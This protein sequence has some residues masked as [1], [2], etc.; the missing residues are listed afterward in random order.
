MSA[1]FSQ[2]LTTDDQKSKSVITFN[3]VSRRFG[4]KHALKNISI[5]IP[6]GGVFGL[7]GVNGA[8]KT[9]LIKHVLGLLRAKQGSVNVF[10]LNPAQ[11]PEKVL[12][13]IGYMSEVAELPEWM[14]TWE[15][16]R[17]TKAFYPNW[18][19]DYCKH[20]INLFEID[21]SMK[22]RALS[23]GQKARVAL[24]LALSHRPELLILD[25]PSSGLDPLVRRDILRTVIQ[26]VA[27]DG[28]TVLFSSHLLEEVERIADHI[29]IIDKGNVIA[30]SSLDEL[31]LKYH[32]LSV[33]FENTPASKPA[34]PNCLA[35]SGSDRHWTTIFQGPSQQANDV[36]SQHKGTVINQSIPNLDEIFF[37]LASH[38]N[39]SSNTSANTGV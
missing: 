37:A 23:K 8:G 27:D 11:H 35:W 25:E 10:G 18:S 33:V 20:L 7:V 31:K 14:A 39:Q 30:Q 17:Y 6:T 12:A 29:A 15:L 19:N 24:L 36:I 28:R 5:D 9:T 16:I 38:K 26:N 21:E 1:H 32:R 2:A 13:K 22:V 4:D 3:K 34:I